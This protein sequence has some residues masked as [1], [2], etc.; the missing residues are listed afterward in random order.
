TS[1]RVPSPA[2]RVLAER[3][4][5]ATGGDLLFARVDVAPDAEGEPLV[6]EVELT[7]PSL[8]FALSKGAEHAMARSILERISTSKPA[9]KTAA[10]PSRALPT[11]AVEDRIESLIRQLRHGTLEGRVQAQQE[12]VRCGAA[13]APRLIECLR[14]ARES[15]RGVAAQ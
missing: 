6:L 7:E 10:P 3:V 4:I 2:E 13:A 12:L 15:M 8:F 11:V 9:T 1:L 14:D 5:D